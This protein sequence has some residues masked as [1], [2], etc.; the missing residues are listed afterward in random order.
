F[1]TIFIATMIADHQVHP[2][3]AWT[4]ALTAGTAFGLIM[5]ILIQRFRLPAF[6]VTLGGLFF[7]R[8][9]AFVI[10]NESVQISHPFYK[11]MNKIVLPIGGGAE[12]SFAA[13]LFL[14]LLGGMI[15]VLHY[16][17]FGRN[18][19]ALGGDEQSA[20]LMGRPVARTQIAVYAINGFCSSLAGIAMTLYMRSGDP[21]KGMAL[22]LD[23]IAVVV[24][25]GTLLTGGVGY[26]TGTLLGVLIYGTI[27]QIKLFA[28]LPSSLAT[29][30]IGG[31]LLAFILLQKVVGVRR[32]N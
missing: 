19:Y 16:T 10:K 15:V 30:A 28:E 8:G 21:T 1:T 6:L 17:R 5:G 24:I 32:Q 22:E 25:G 3:V 12:L 29:L 7:A 18:V 31:L 9:M 20:L 13:M 26:V 11:T 2:L 4:F 27:Y 14:A 23:A